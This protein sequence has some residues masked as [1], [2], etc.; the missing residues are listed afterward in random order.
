M[1]TYGRYQFFDSRVFGQNEKC[2]REY[3]EDGIAKG[4]VFNSCT[5]ARARVVLLDP[6][7]EFDTIYPD[8]KLPKLGPNDAF[9]VPGKDESSWQ[10]VQFANVKI[11]L[12]SEFILQLFYEEL[13]KHKE[14]PFYGKM[15]VMGLS[16]QLQR[17]SDDIRVYDFKKFL[18]I[19]QV[20]QV[21]PTFGNKDSFYLIMNKNHFLQT[22]KSQIQEYKYND[23]FEFFL[24]H[25]KRLKLSLNE[26]ID[27]AMGRQLSNALLFNFT[28]RMDV[29]LQDS[30]HKIR[31][32]ILPRA[33]KIMVALDV[34]DMVYSSV[35]IV[36][37][38]NSLRFVVPFL[39]IT[40]N[41]LISFLLVLNFAL[42]YHIFGLSL[43]D[44]L[45]HFGIMR[46]LGFVR[47][48]LF[49]VLVAQGLFLSFIA[50]VISLPFTFL[51][52][53][54]FN[55]MNLP[56]NLFGDD[57]YPTA[58]AVVLAALSNLVV[59]QVSLLMP[60]YKFFS[61]KIMES[62]DNRA[63]LFSSLKAKNDT[64]SNIFGRLFIAFCFI[65]RHSSL[66]KLQIKIF[67]II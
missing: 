29:Y 54:G 14:L 28:D 10:N 38:L 4:A 23:T 18:N 2:S 16:E 67:Y 8:Y 27:R 43:Q 41:T 15:T 52:F 63:E 36:H 45:F 50:F 12:P 26:M 56:I 64:K 59:P 51:F 17:A 60:G 47:Y 33:N 21:I 6:D 40:V 37:E 3:L 49:F 9:I 32:N 30:Y 5:E 31:S 24:A 39:K 65:Y 7:L 61:K 22:W 46:T 57:I 34:E 25:Q 48:K 19:K 42:I 11:E 53:Y 62:I 1:T 58:V 55:G 35:P 13:S 44:K 66:K 20:G